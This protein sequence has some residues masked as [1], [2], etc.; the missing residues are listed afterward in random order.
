[1]ALLAA[2]GLASEVMAPEGAA[3]NAAIPGDQLLIKYLPW[4]LPVARS[5]PTDIAP[6][7]G[8]AAEEDVKVR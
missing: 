1:M 4:A 2:E 3:A 5:T 8:A 7:R 6:A